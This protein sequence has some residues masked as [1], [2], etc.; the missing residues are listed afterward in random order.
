[1]SLIDSRANVALFELQQKQFERDGYLVLRDFAGQSQLAELRL[2]AAECVAGGLGP[3][4]FE[5]DVGYPGAPASRTDP[6][7]GTTRR[8]LHA[9]SRS[10]VFL[11]WALSQPVTDVLRRLLATSAVM[12]SQ[13]HHNCIMTKYPGFG[14]ATLWHQDN[15][16]WSFDQ[17]N[18]VTQWLALGEETR[19]NG[20]LRVI[21]GSHL[22]DLDR[23]RFD[24][25]LFLRP[26]LAENKRLLTTAVPVQL[27]PGDL[28]LFHSR[29]FHA[30]GRNR[31]DVVKLS[32]VFTHHATSNRPIAGTRSAQYP[33]LDPDQEP[34]GTPG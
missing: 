30:A 1:M 12:L 4:E 7:G 19:A 10:P 21:P 14:S 26:D 32:L 3:V 2:A 33:S 23:G 11:N 27:N 18:L 29:L 15:R 5:A 8:M 24:A 34:R 16:Y 9:I 6:G 22:L 13:C 25:D 17:E 31:A 20:C 28:L